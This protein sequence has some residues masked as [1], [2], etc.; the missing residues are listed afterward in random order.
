MFL[1]CRCCTQ[2]SR[3]RIFL[4]L[5]VDSNREIGNY[6]WPRFR[7]YYRARTLR[8]LIV[9][10]AAFTCFHLTRNTCR[11]A[12]IHNREASPKSFRFVRV[13]R[14]DFP[15]KFSDGDSSGIF[16]NNDENGEFKRDSKGLETCYNTIVSV[17][18]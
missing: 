3:V 13:R 1:R 10:C 18:V 15:D 14:V 12:P 4:S 5:S 17:I 6:R 11:G 2:L 16:I 8:R 7:M 9:R